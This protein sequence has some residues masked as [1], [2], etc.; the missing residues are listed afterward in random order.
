MSRLFCCWCQKLTMAI[1]GL[2]T[3]CCSQFSYNNANLP[4]VE[5]LAVFN[6]LYP[7]GCGE[8]AEPPRSHHNRDWTV[9]GK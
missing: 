4:F 5:F 1:K 7:Q 3:E 6:Q 9:Q 2:N 8:T